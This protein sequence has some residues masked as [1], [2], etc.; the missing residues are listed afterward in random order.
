MTRKRHAWVSATCVSVALLGLSAMNALPAL[1][2]VH[3]LGARQAAAVSSGPFVTLLFSRTEI[4]AADNCVR[5]DSGI[6]RL[7]TVVAPYLKARGMPGTGTLTTARTQENALTCTHSN[8][9]LTSSWAQATALSQQYGWTYVSHTAT[10]PSNLAGLTPSQSQAETCGSAAAIDSHGLP[11]GHGMIAYPG[12][13]PLPVALQTDYAAK[14]FAWG[15]KYGSKGVTLA[16]AGSVS[17]FW[18]ITAVPNGGPCNVSTA[19]CYTIQA[20]GSKRYVLPSGFVSTVRSLSPGQWFT[21]QAFIL[22]TGKS[23]AY[24]T[25]PIRWDCTS[26]NVRRHWTNDNERYCYQDWQSVVAAIAAA[27]E[28]IVPIA[29]VEGLP[30]HAA[31][32]ERAVTAA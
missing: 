6:A 21:F 30:L 23:P 17:P 9:S 11:G 16:A 29:R 15:R 10:Y 18:Q 25:S 24:S 27:A 2:Q 19:S 12:A 32:V 3:P 8:S 7:D 5:N 22:V 31:A 13:Q 4:S 20:T 26:T 1:P 14:C 28:V